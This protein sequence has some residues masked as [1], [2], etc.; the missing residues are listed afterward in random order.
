MP[1]RTVI[2]NVPES[3]K[4]QVYG[5]DLNQP[6]QVENGALSVTGVVGIDSVNPISVSV[7]AL[8]DVTIANSLTIASLPNVTIANSLTIASL[9]N[10]TIAN[11]LTIA[12]LPNV[13]IANSLT[14]ASLPNVTIANS[15]TIA[16][17]PNVTIANSLTIASL[18]NVTIA[19]SVTIAGS[20]S[21]ILSARQTVNTVLNL[22]FATTTVSTPI[23]DVADL[24]DFSYFFFSSTSVT[25]Y[26]YVSPITNPL[27][28]VTS[29]NYPITIDEAGIG[30]GTPDRYL[31]YT[32]AQVNAAG[33]DAGES[34]TVYL[35][36]LV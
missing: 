28:P 9:P 23:Y 4:T 1:N 17:L 29:P 10:V 34:V 35:Q 12:S 19:N 5:S 31:F 2:N 16:S 7:D 14:I 24:Y 30:I 32:Y 18:P 36:G 21:V 11:S 26:I 33:V 8:P 22:S 3:L 6:L 15:L 25:A 20:P 27:L 13:T